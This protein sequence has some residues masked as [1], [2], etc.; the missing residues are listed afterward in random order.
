[1]AVGLCRRRTSAGTGPL[2]KI[3]LT[4]DTGHPVHLF[5]IRGSLSALPRPLP[6]TPALVLTLVTLHS[7]PVTAFKTLVRKSQTWAKREPPS[8]PPPD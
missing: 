7:S 3:R 6:P 4:P 5:T 1:M 2:Q 8:R